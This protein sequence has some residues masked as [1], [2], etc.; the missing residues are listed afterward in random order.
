MPAPV[1]HQRQKLQVRNSWIQAA[2]SAGGL[3]YCFYS[4]WMCVLTVCVYVCTHTALTW[5]LHFD[6]SKTF[7]HASVPHDLN[8]PV[9]FFRFS[10]HFTL[11]NLTFSFT[12]KTAQMTNGLNEN[13]K[14]LDGINSGSR[15]QQETT[16]ASNSSI[17]GISGETC[18]SALPGINIQHR[19][20]EQNHSNPQRA[21]VGQY[22]A[23]FLGPPE[24]CCCFC[25]TG[26]FSELSYDSVLRWERSSS[27]YHWTEGTQGFWWSISLMCDHWWRMRLTRRPQRKRLL[28]SLQTGFWPSGS[29]SWFVL[30]RLNGLVLKRQTFRRRSVSLESLHGSL[31]HC[32]LFLSCVCVCC[33][34]LWDRD[35]HVTISVTF[36]WSVALCWLVFVGGS[37][38]AFV[39]SLQLASASFTSIITT[40]K[41]GPTLKKKLYSCNQETDLRTWAAINDEEL[42]FSYISSADMSVFRSHSWQTDWLYHCEPSIPN[43][44]APGAGEEEITCWIASMILTGPLHLIFVSIYTCTFCRW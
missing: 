2:T 20:A 4:D 34:F 7:W 27:C 40:C 28:P 35:C 15:P 26:D 36:G 43:R 9:I 11:V 32:L 3:K 22:S 44:A 12:P 21:T 25:V 1:C 29:S 30:S 13:C 5:V 41:T 33:F 18:S 19:L 39:V 14:G 37:N 24:S 16:A 8:L 6:W 23:D 42:I 31:P 38:S 17:K 10:E